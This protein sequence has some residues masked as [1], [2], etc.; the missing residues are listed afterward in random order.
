MCNRLVL[1][2]Y[3]YNLIKREWLRLDDAAPQEDSD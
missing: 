3:V 2:T 1:N